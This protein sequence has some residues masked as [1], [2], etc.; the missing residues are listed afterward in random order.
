LPQ[1]GDDMSHKRLMMIA[2]ILTTAACT[3]AHAINPPD[4]S[5]A[6]SCDHVRLYEF[7]GNDLLLTTIDASGERT[8]TA[9]WRKVG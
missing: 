7:S 1:G 5:D 3:A 6:I 2:L 8:A 4:V 9:K